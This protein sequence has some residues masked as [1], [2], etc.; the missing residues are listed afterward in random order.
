MTLL[1]LRKSG[2]EKC[3]DAVAF[4]TSNINAGF[5]S[6]K[7]YCRLK[8]PEMLFGVVPNFYI[9]GNAAFFGRHASAAPATFPS[10]EAVILEVKEKITACPS[11]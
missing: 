2:C 5:K 4:V 7:E 6:I 1:L 8:H 11:N 10:H 3:P 9:D